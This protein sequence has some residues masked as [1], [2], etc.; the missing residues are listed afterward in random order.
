MTDRSTSAPANSAGICWNE[1]PY[2][3]PTTSGVYQTRN[4]RNQVWFKY[5]DAMYSIW[6]MSWAEMKNNP[7]RD[8]AK[9]RIPD[10]AVHVLAWARASKHDAK[11]QARDRIRRRLERLQSP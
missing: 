9:L 5:F 4:D 1:L 10:I 2:E 8:T 7:T 6:Y 11:T 3:D